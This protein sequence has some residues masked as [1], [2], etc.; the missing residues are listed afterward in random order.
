MSLTGKVAVV[1]GAG[2]EVG[3]AVTRI[4]ATRGATVLIVDDD[5]Q[6]LA[7]L[8]DEFPGAVEACVADVRDPV[9]V[10]R[11][12]ARA[13]EL[14]GGIDL[15][16]NN[17]DVEGPV[18]SLVEY[19]DTAFD[20][21]IAGNLRATFLGLKHT[22]P[23]LR[24]GGAVVNLASDLGVVA[25]PGLGGY[26]ASKHGVLGLTKVA[27]LECQRRGIRVNAVCPTREVVLDGDGDGYETTEDI[28]LLV[29]FLLSDAG[30]VHH[31]VDV[32]GAATSDALEGRRA[33]NNG[34][35]APVPA[36]RSED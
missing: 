35:G 12:V 11:F 13:V 15:F 8:V 30:P 34:P 32:V 33:R 20:E 9:G 26:V 4:L 18:H 27:A 14:W 5:A 10:A 19:P 23:H 16:F 36:G 2:G 25:A 7:R 6:A 21:M 29:A 17:V 1:T 22:L 24:D 3:A 31:R 28:A